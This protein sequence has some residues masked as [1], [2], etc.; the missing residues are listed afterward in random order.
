MPQKTTFFMTRL[1]VEFLEHAD[2]FS[3]VQV[4]VAKKTMRTHNSLLVSLPGAD[5]MKDRFHLRIRL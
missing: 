3:L 4:Q 2:L 1:C 5:G